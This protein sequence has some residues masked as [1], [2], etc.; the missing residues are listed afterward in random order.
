MLPQLVTA[1]KRV[2]IAKAAMEDRS[3]S[4]DRPADR[5]LR[6]GRQENREIR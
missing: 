1:K 6:V 3:S 2:S 4:V 5:E